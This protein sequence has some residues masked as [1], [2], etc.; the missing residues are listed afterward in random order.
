M[1]YQSDDEALYLRAYAHYDRAD[2]EKIAVTARLR[3]GAAAIGGFNTLLRQYPWSNRFDNSQYYLGRAYIDRGANLAASY[4]GAVMSPADS[5]G[6]RAAY[7]IAPTPLRQ[8]DYRSNKRVDALYYAVYA[9]RKA[10]AWGAAFSSEY[11]IAAFN[12]IVA[13]FPEHGAAARS[14]LQI[15]HVYRENDNALQARA[16]FNRIV[17]HYA[18]TDSYDNA[19]YWSGSAALDLGDSAGARTRFEQFIQRQQARAPDE[20]NVNYGNALYW[21]GAISFYQNDSAAA[22]DRLQRYV[23]LQEAMPVDLRGA[24][25]DSAVVLIAR[26]TGQNTQKDTAGGGA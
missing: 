7:T 23:A 24:Y 8:I 3:E 9:E 21:S 16:S 26:I 2:D 19:L 13:T 6:I 5:A 17:E 15:G 22:L 1:E 10:A 4:A 20:R 11:L 12:N 14:L 18:G 25:Y